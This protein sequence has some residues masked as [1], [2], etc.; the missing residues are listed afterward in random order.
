MHAIR[1]YEFGGPE[2]LVWEEVPDLSP[3]ADQVR[4]DV[5]ASGVHLVDT[6]IRK[7]DI[8][9]TP[10][11]LPDLPMTPG[12]EAAGVVDAVGEDVDPA[13]VG[14]RVVAHLGFAS[15]GYADSAVREVTAVHEI[16]EG[17]GFAQALAVI[18]TGRTT[19]IVLHYAGLSADDTVIVTAAAGGIGNLLVQ[20]A[21]RV[22]AFT[23]GLAGGPEKARRVLDA[24]ADAAVDYRA[25]DWSASLERALEGREATVLL[26]G[27]GGEAADTAFEQIVPG[28]RVLVF[29]WS[30]GSAVPVDAQRLMDRGVSFIPSLGPH[31]VAAAGGLP[32]LEREALRRLAQGEWRPLVSRFPMDGAAEAHRALEERLTAGKV[33]LERAES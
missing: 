24:G 20:E 31:A 22:G 7:G 6:S 17:A 32:K 3:A 1:Q 25:E 11:G 28:G 29:G 26:D 30:S 9:H 23:V 16:P 13:W 5:R 2:K 8:A 14:K 12:R 19:L 21:K 18:G 33:V 15:G 10:W 4:I 27:V